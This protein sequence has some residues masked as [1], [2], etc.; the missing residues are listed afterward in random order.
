MVFGVV[1]VVFGGAGVV[2]KY[3]LIGVAEYNNSSKIKKEQKLLRRKLVVLGRECTHPAA[4]FQCEHES[5]DA[6]ADSEQRDPVA[7]LNMSFFHREC[8]GGRH[9]RA[10]GVAEKFQ[11]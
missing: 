3:R 9:G 6:G 10:A 5:V 11:R 4:L 7:R 8:G 2:L 1:G